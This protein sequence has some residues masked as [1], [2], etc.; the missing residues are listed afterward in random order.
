MREGVN[1]IWIHGLHNAMLPGKIDRVI[2]VIWNKTNNLS[3]N[4]FWLTS[5]TKPDHV[6]ANETHKVHNSML[7][8]KIYRL[9]TTIWNTEWPATIT[10]HLCWQVEQKPSSINNQSSFPLTTIG[11]HI[12][13]AIYL[14][15]ALRPPVH[16]SRVSHSLSHHAFH[17]RTVHGAT[18]Q[19]GAS[20]AY[21]GCLPVRQSCH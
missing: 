13:S 15:A 5:W 11:F 9:F 6:I 19:S 10:K 12:L 18:I 3:T 8:D 1:T 2:T 20:E 21:D 7:P 17:W 4:F 14:I 16:Q